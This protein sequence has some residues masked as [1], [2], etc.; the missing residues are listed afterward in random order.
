M[1][2][3]DI[4]QIEY[5]VGEIG[6]MEVGPYKRM[7]VNPLL[8]YTVE[9]WGNSR[10]YYYQI[11]FYQETV[12]S[13]LTNFEGYQSIKNYRIYLGSLKEHGL[14]NELAKR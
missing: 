6:S 9:P 11:D 10:E 1:I 2:E 4:Y 13:F 7:L 14:G 12:K 8:I 5:G 3:I